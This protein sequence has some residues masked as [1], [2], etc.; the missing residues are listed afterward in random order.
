[1]SSNDDP[2]FDALAGLPTIASDTEREAR[3]LARCHA[4][5][6]KRSMRSAAATRA[7]GMLLASS[8]AVL[9]AY[10]AVTFAEVLRLAAHP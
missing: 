9:C 1:M 3:V 6:H 5:M 7:S 2:I 4:K 10:L 8:A